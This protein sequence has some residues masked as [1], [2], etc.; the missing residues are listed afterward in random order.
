[1]AA[2]RLTA[3]PFMFS[4]SRV[5]GSRVVMAKRVG[6]WQALTCN[7]LVITSHVRVITSHVLVITSNVLVITSK[8]LVKVKKSPSHGPSFELVKTWEADNN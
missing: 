6:E 3:P 8:V 4:E 7:V 5:S 2:A 1:M